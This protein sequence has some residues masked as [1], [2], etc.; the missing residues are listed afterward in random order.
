MIDSWLETLSRETLFGP[1]RGDNESATSRELKPETP[2]IIAFPKREHTSRDDNSSEGHPGNPAVLHGGSLAGY[3]PEGARSKSGGHTRQHPLPPTSQSLPHPSGRFLSERLSPLRVPLAVAPL[4][5][6]C[7]AALYRRYGG[8]SLIARFRVRRK[9]SRTRFHVDAHRKQL[10]STLRFTFWRSAGLRGSDYE[11]ATYRYV[12]W[13]FQ[14]ALCARF[15]TASD[16]WAQ[17]GHEYFSRIFTHFLHAKK[18]MEQY[19]S[20]NFLGVKNWPK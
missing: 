19:Y 11:D 6:A 10:N 20:N 8:K 16:V 12:G 2:V 5:A 1:K 15:R 14:L 13:P 9:E 18:M 3:A 4:C 7:A 17:N